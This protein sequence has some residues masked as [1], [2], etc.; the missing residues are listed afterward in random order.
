M[1]KRGFILAMSLLLCVLLLVLGVGFLG[2]RAAQ[3]QAA[4]AE[5]LAAQA[6][7]LA[8]AGLEDA[9]VKLDKDLF[10]PP[11]GDVDQDHFS[12]QEELRDASGANRVGYYL[13]T[14]DEAR[15]SAPD[16]PDFHYPSVIVVTSTG[17]VG[18]DPKQPQAA[19]TLRMEIDVDEGEPGPPVELPKV[20]FKVSDYTDDVLPEL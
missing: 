2:K 13:V 5:G 19:V 12:Y 8:E 3:S 17:C 1:K 15:R 9:R 11:P 10:F 4:A 6:R 14:V 20:P 18:Q 16:P 7:A